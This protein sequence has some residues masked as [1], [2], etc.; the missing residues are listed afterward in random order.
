[1]RAIDRSCYDDFIE[2]DSERPADRFLEPVLLDDVKIVLT[3]IDPIQ[4][5]IKQREKNVCLVEFPVAEPNRTE[6][7]RIVH[8]Y[9]SSM[10]PDIR[11]RVVQ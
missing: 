4:I 2:V 3:D 1:M 11:S 10:S 9:R 5:F 7:D 6:N 8:V